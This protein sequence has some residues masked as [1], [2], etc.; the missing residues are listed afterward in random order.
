MIVYSTS[1]TEVMNEIRH[2]IMKTFLETF[3]LAK[4]KR[5]SPLSGYDLTSII[6][7]Q[8]KFTLSP[9][10][11]YSTLY[12]LERKGLIGPIA[13]NSKRKRAYRLTE[14]GEELLEMNLKHVDRIVSF[15]REIFAS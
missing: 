2:N 14:E 1:E 12:S 15:V 3:I 7:R 10:T 9:A 8:F 6:Y 4:L 5:T 13:A 11:V